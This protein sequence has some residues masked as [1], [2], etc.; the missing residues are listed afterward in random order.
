MYGRG[1]TAWTLLSAVVVILVVRARADE[2]SW[3]GKTIILKK[4][5][6]KV[7][8]TADDGKQVY[9]ATLRGLDYLVGG[10]QDGW[11]LV[12]SGFG[13]EGWFDK[14][15]AVLLDR[16]V[17]YFTAAIERNPADA[18]A[19]NRRGWARKLTGALGPAIQD[20]SAS[21]RL[22]PEA[23]VF[24][25]R[26]AAWCDQARYDRAIRD[27]D[28]ALRLDPHYAPAL[29]NRGNARAC[30]KDYDAAIRDYAEV[31]RLQPDCAAAF[32]NRGQVWAL[33]KDHVK[34]LRDFNQAM[35]LEPTLFRGTGPRPTSAAFDEMLDWWADLGD[36]VMHQSQ[37]LSQ[38]LSAW[39][40]QSRGDQK[41][42]QSAP[43]LRPAK[44]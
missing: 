28:E 26:A 8:Y 42:D 27:C 38:R 7:G 14:E 29:N 1:L 20:F 32:H 22:A 18:D 25:N 37:R 31:I 23:A 4:T 35:R 11:L 10:E 3:V 34:A 44:R 15:D 41:T 30:N 12:P 6:I 33:K 36:E 21:L 16:A 40:R 13:V 5:G 39:L 19:Y 17:A 24:N 43:S 9:V 2:P